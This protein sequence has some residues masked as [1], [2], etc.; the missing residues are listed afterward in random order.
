MC[1]MSDA[2][3]V[4]RSLASSL[5]AYGRPMVLSLYTSNVVS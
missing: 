1:K 5:I 2:I 3:D 4:D